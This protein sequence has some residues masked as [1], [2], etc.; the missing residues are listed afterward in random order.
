MT[1]FLNEQSD[2]SVASTLTPCSFTCPKDTQK[3]V[4][5]AAQ[6]APA[7]LTLHYVPGKSSRFTPDSPSSFPCGGAQK[8]LC[9]SR[10]TSITPWV[11]AML[12][13]HEP[14]PVRQTSQTIY[15]LL[16]LRP[17]PAPLVLP[18]PAS[19]VPFYENFANRLCRLH[20][21]T[22]TRPSPCRWA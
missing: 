6:R 20:R 14:R 7:L 21:L 8:Y 22:H 17:T 13:P 15:A 12:R 10:T 2:K 9:A 16:A 1:K 18:T 5:S 11:F 19:L 4:P 3:F